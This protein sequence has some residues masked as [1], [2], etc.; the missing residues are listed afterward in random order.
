MKRF[1]QF[2]LVLLLSLYGCQESAITEQTSDGLVGEQVVFNLSFAQSEAE[3]K[4]RSAVSSDLSIS[5]LLCDASGYVIQD[6]TSLYREGQSQIVFEPLAVGSYTLYVLGY[7]QE[8]IDAGMVIDSD[9][10]S[11][12]DRWFHFN[13]SELM[14]IADSEL[15]YGSYE[16]YIE[17]DASVWY[18][19]TLNYQLSAVNVNKGE[20]SPYLSRSI[21]S[22]N[23]VPE[24]AVS[25]FDSFSVEGEFSGAKP[26]SLEPVSML[27]TQTLYFMPSVEQ[28]SVKFGIEINTLSHD[29]RAGR[30]Q[31]SFNAELNS[32][33]FTEVAMD[34]SRHPDYNLGTM[35]VT[36][37][38]VEAVGVPRILQDDEPKEIYY[39]G[40]HRSFY[41]NKPLQ[42]AKSESD[43]GITARLYS[44]VGMS[45]VTIW[46]QRNESDPRVAVAYF[47]S[48]PDFAD[49]D[50]RLDISG[51]ERV[52]LR[53]DGG[54]Y[55]SLDSTQIS[56]Y[57]DGT[58]TIES[59]CE[60]WAK[61]QTIRA[62]WFIEYH[63]YEG[64]PDEPDGG[65]AGNWIGLRP[66]H[67]REGVAFLLNAAYMIALDDFA[68][69]LATYQG[70]INSNAGPGYPLDLSIVIPQMESLYRFNLGLVY[71][72]NGVVG[73]GGGS[74]LGVSQ[75][76]YFNHYDNLHPAETFFH[77][78]G[79]CMGYSHDSGMSY[80][81]WSEQ[82]C[83]HFYN[84]NL[85]RFPVYSKS[86]LN[87]VNNPNRYL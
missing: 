28:G 64:D 67:A 80:G 63:H 66:V 15:L 7:N 38:D 74:V 36:L 16:F 81:P 11:S 23:L 44:P 68:A 76:S 18:D 22:Y 51:D 31:H 84:D 19:L 50:F 35:W 43:N 20:I 8:M 69:E 42:V 45:D 53:T 65:P 72:G 87:S 13:V 32:N 83:N 12:R 60:F 34:L 61:I 21:T 41:V 2:V 27:N 37:D 75:S 85:H 56:S 14:P 29:S 6:V 62:G 86:I 4:S 48:I 54:N 33:H 78:I 30:I 73:L 1:Y 17:D 25:L 59:S 47:D 57:L 49:L 5:Y 39:D 46:A 26:L 71:T 77:E 58:L 10:E 55:I 3:A 52:E 70:L 79:H 40:A 9:I 24:A 82:L